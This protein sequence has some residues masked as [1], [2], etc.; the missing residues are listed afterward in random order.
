MRRLLFAALFVADFATAVVSV[1]PRSA[2]SGA[3][4]PGELREAR[5]V[6]RSEQSVALQDILASVTD[7]QAIFLFEPT[8]LAPGEETTLRFV[9]GA[10]FAELLERTD[11]KFTDWQWS[12]GA[13]AQRPEFLY[14]EIQLFAWR[15]WMKHLV[16][17]G[18]LTAG[19]VLLAFF[20]ARRAYQRHIQRRSLRAEAQALKS[21]VCAASTL[22]SFVE[23]WI[24]RDQL[25]VLFPE[26]A[27]SLMHFYNVLNK[28]QFKMSVSSDELKE[29]QQEQARLAAALAEAPRGV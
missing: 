20:P 1:V 29:I 11:L 22:E 8:T 13:P 7:D 16:L 9:A 3:L 24:L 28:Y 17:L 15:W 6:N 2:G 5:V 25:K 23:I 10:K 12:V 18:V 27:E 14:E 4:S 21:K 19:G 26:Q